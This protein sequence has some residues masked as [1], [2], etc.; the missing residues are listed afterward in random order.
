MSNQF[1]S[2]ISYRFIL[3]ILPAFFLI[4]LIFLGALSYFELI[5][6]KKAYQQSM[7]DKTNNLALL[8][9][10]PVWQLSTKLSK[11][12]LKATMKDMDIICIRLEQD[13]DITP[14]VMH[15]GCDQITE[16]STVFY[17]NII[18]SG[19]L[20]TRNLGAV[21]IY[22]KDHNK[23]SSITKQL[24]PLAALSLILFITLIVITI[25]AFRST[26][27]A[28]LITISQSLKFYRKTGQ[29]VPVNW[30]TSDELGQLIKEYN[31]NL[32]RQTETEAALKDAHIKTEA[33]LINLKEAHI[34]L[35]QSE[36]MASLGSLVAGI[37]HEINTPLGNSLTVATTVTEM[38][39]QIKADIDNGQLTKS[40]LDEFIES[41]TEAST[42]LERNLHRAAKQIQNFKNVAVDQTSEKRRVFDVKEVIYENIYILKPLIKHTPFKIEVSV[43]TGISM[44]SFPGP[45]GQIITNCFHNA[46][47]HGFESRKNGLISI[48]ASLVSDKW[49]YLEIADNGKGMTVTE[50]EKAFD[51][52]YTTKLGKGGS[53]L[54]LNLVY[55]LTTTILGGTVDIKSSVDM[56][57]TFNFRLPI[58]APYMG[59]IKGNVS[60]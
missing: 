47:L 24:K 18:Y 20:S 38:T 22:T 12:I 36:K 31:D 48:K 7:Q 23:W 11:N 51:P 42:I 52:F 46:L 19:V 10:E 54:G 25:T 13:S 41:I 26:I 44:D 14:L 39:H 40:A 17:S 1:K 6:A 58:S 60:V 35:I 57:V 32:I 50:C 28:P 34:N 55:N 33:A 37:A 5:N 59:K 30:N 27:I 56:G 29:R 43:P 4:S 8:L 9:T 21:F 45:L 49:L 3:K 16:Q 15:G 53:G 2:S